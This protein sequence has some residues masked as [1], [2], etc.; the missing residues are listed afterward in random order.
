[1]K[2]SEEYRPGALDAPASAV[3]VAHVVY[4]LHAFAIVVG[5][6]GSP[7]VVGSF[8]GSF[9]SIAGVVL[10]YVKRS[11]ARGTWLASHYRWQIRT[12]WF[13]LV[14][15]IV[16]GVLFVTLIGIPLA[17]VVLAVVTVWIAYRIVRGWRRLG[18]RSPMY[19]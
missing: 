15:L 9:P 14:W 11:E 5:I 13:A 6:L 19:A 17:F 1:M 16:A 8:L 12:F 18:R 2:D 3:T 4:G 10:N 7:T